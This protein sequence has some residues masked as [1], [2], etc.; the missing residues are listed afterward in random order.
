MHNQTDNLNSNIT[1]STDTTAETTEH[2]FNTPDGETKSPNLGYTVNLNIPSVSLPS[3]KDNKLSYFRVDH[4]NSSDISAVISQAGTDPNDNKDVENL[5]HEGDPDNIT[6]YNCTS[7]TTN[8]DAS[9]RLS[10]SNSVDDVTSLENVTELNVSCPTLELY[11]SY[12]NIE[13]P[14]YNFSERDDHITVTEARSRC[15]N[16]KF[17]SNISNVDSLNECQ[18]ETHRPHDGVIENCDTNVIH[19]LGAL[20]HD[21]VGSSYDDFANIEDVFNDVKQ[22]RNDFDVL[23]ASSGFRSPD[24]I[25]TSATDI[26]TLYSSADEYESDNVLYFDFEGLNPGLDKN[27]I[28]NTTLYITRSLECVDLSDIDMASDVTNLDV[29]ELVNSSEISDIPF[30]EEYLVKQQTKHC[31]SISNVEDKNVL[32]KTSEHHPSENL[33]LHKRGKRFRRR[34]PAGLMVPDESSTSIDD[35]TDNVSFLPTRRRTGKAK[36]V[37]L[38]ASS[39]AVPSSSSSSI[40]DIMGLNLSLEQSLASS[41]DEACFDDLIDPIYAELSCPSA[42]FEKI[43]S[44]ADSLPSD[45]FISILKSRI[46]L[47]PRKKNPRNIKLYFQQV[48]DCTSSKQHNEGSELSVSNLNDKKTLIQHQTLDAGAGFSSLDD[49]Q[50]FFAHNIEDSCTIPSEISS[51]SKLKNAQCADIKLHPSEAHMLSETHML[52]E[53]HMLS[54]AH[55]LSEA[56]MRSEAHML[57]EAHMRSDAEGGYHGNHDGT[58]CH[59]DIPDNSRNYPN[60]AHTVHRGDATTLYQGETC[61]EYQISTPAEFTSDNSAGCEKAAK[62]TKFSPA[63]DHD[64]TLTEIVGDTPTQYTGDTPT[65]FTSKILSESTVD[66]SIQYHDNVPA[67]HTEFCH[68]KDH[69]ETIIECTV[70]TPTEPVGDTSTE[71]IGY[72]T[73]E[74]IGY[75]TTEPIGYT[76][77]DPI[78][79]TPTEPIGDT[80]TEP[81]GDTPTEPIGSTPTEPIGSTLTEPV[82]DT[83]TEPVGST[84]TEPVGDTSTEPVGDTPTEPVGSTPTEPVG[85]TSTEPVGDTPTEP[86]GSTPTEPVGD[87]STEYDT[88]L[89]NASGECTFDEAHQTAASTFKDTETNFQKIAVRNEADI[90]GI[91]FRGKNKVKNTDKISLKVGALSTT[92]FNDDGDLSDVDDD[93]DSFERSLQ[94]DAYSSVL[95]EL[96]FVNKE[97]LLKPVITPAEP[98]QSSVKDEIPTSSFT[99]YQDISFCESV[100]EMDEYHEA[101]H[102]Q[103]FN[104]VT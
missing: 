74:P 22:E 59:I 34:R 81:V 64:K 2:L 12:E 51:Y 97:S 9:E 82:G 56:H 99:R 103:Y 83:P 95:R 28:T 61:S 3:L 100:E 86:V 63:K 11:S 4:Y 42:D 66:A 49:N 91:Y 48:D 21:S 31:Q 7:K 16:F 69:D 77:T 8:K 18:S 80:P 19:T 67:D 41:L 72:N 15:N 79:D 104:Q 96:L 71:P 73:T 93:F 43:R 92:I 55:M 58:V 10:N 44:T 89:D 23:S 88:S 38:E 36:N 26:D 62:H 47:N 98:Q 57:S 65:E 94:R 102:Q 27:I 17:S 25:A 30:L 24:R 101:L 35:L 32:P 33:P 39:E 5:A 84:P 60:L 87:T 6:A 29:F 75:N 90:E 54:D 78:G 68:A 76:P 53:E 14:S 20:S 45:N 85:D 13:D 40:V 1:E 37:G 50:T 52:S 46:A 70:D